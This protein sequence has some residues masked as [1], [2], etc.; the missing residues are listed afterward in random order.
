M[1]KGD[2]KIESLDNVGTRKKAFK[3]SLLTAKH[4]IMLNTQNCPLNTLKA[5]KNVRLMIREARKIIIDGAVIP[6]N[7][8]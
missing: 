2:E 8:D 3:G 7:K 4:A 5:R 6:T 1:K